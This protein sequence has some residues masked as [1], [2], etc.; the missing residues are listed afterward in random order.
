MLASLVF[1]G[2]PP[3]TAVAFSS[4]RGGRLLGLLWLLRFER[5]RGLRM[6]NLSIYLIPALVVTL[7]F[8]GPYS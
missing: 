1:L 2:W 8:M 7:F 5:P 3:T 6:R 4:T